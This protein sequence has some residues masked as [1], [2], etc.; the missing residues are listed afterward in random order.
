MMPMTMPMPIPMPI[1]IPIY[2][3]PNIEIMRVLNCTVVFA[4]PSVAPAA[5]GGVIL[6][7]S[8]L[9]LTVIDFFP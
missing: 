7:N 9:P 8:T 4:V 1:R 6:D 5:G 2:T 3:L